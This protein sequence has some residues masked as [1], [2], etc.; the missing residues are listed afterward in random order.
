ME[1]PINTDDPSPEVLADLS[2]L[3]DGTLDPAREAALREQLARSPELSERLEREQ[4][5]VAAL[6]TVRADRAPERLRAR[7]DAQRRQ[8]S[9]GP[10]PRLGMA[11]GT[12]AVAAVAVAA[13]ALVLVLPAGTPGGPSVSQAASLALKGSAMAA[14]LPGG[15]VPGAT[16]NRDVQDVY[17]PNWSRDFGWWARGQRVDRINGRAAVTVYYASRGGKRIAYTIVAA[18]ALKL[19]HANTQLIRG[20]EVQTFAM[21]ERTVVT[22]RRAGHTCVLSGVGV[23]PAELARLA[24]WKLPA[25]AS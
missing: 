8:R 22:W 23:S 2:A 6:A 3:A 11:W 7:I 9:R 25:M 20:T 15:A 24:A 1:D 4:R 17:F 19:P 10:L 16:L 5:A 18:P 13:L 14:P 21:G 12:A